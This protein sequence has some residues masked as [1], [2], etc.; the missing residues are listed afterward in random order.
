M[1]RLFRR[2]CRPQAVISTELCSSLLQ[3]ST[4]IGRQVGLLLDRAG[5]V[6][7][8]IVGSPAEIV[9]PHLGRMRTGGGRLRGLRL[10]HTHLRSEPLSTEDL[11]DLALL[12]LDMVAA[13]WAEEEHKPPKLHMAHI[14][15]EAKDEK[16]WV[17]MPPTTLGQDDVDFAELISWL[18]AQLTRKAGGGDQ[19]ESRKAVLVH[20]SQLPK[21]EAQERLEELNELA[22]TQMITAVETTIYR[23]APHPQTFLGSGRVK[24]LLI[25]AMAQGADMLLF[26]Q[27]LTP[28]QLKWITNLADIPVM[29]RTQ[30]ILSIFAR[31]AHSVDGKL[32]VELA[33]LRYELPRVGAREA[34]LS[35]IRGGIGMRGP[36]ETT[37]ET[38]RRVIKN[39]ISSIEKKLITIGRGRQER[40]KK[41]KRAGLFQ[42]AIIGYTNAGKSTLLNAMTKSH[43]LVEDKL[44]AT[45]DPA[46]RI[47]RYP[48]KM[49]LAISDTVGFIR[50]LPED[51]LEAFRSTL[52]ELGDADLLLHIV[53]VGAP[54]F[55]T[56]IETVEKILTGLNLG[57]IPRK[58]ALNKVDMLDP[59]NA[60][61]ECARYDAL[62]ISAKNGDGVADL[63]EYIRNEAIRMRTEK[64]AA[65]VADGPGFDFRRRE[66]E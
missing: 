59:D 43:V 17:V 39:R 14:N 4:Q 7:R 65:P 12:R 20:L 15:P 23:G 30:L 44:F 48:E 34:A 62:G 36:G 27:D 55:E 32:R 60:A 19:D 13:V 51:L 25:R 11:T 40:K 63:T 33:R 56:F 50:D 61:N 58:L 28:A 42:V 41:R 3:I 49:D 21:R 10:V 8:V 47:V 22:R 54:E 46:T 1:E 16:P 18:E 35:R 29:D 9:I 38:S 5:R 26:D 66:E 2:R 37:A 64:P 6:E 52:E 53:D 24:E 45:L 57:H 31:R